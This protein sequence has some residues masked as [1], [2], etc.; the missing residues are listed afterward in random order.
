[1]KI[2]IIGAGYVG[3]VSA[4][5]FAEI[6]HEVITVDNNSA[7]VERLKAGEVPIHEE[8]L[9]E[10]L[11][12][13]GNKSLRYSDNVAEA[14]KFCDVAF[15]CVGT[16]PSENG[17]A[18][19]SYVEGVARE[20]AVSLDR[21]KVIVEK[22]TVPVGTCDAIKRTLL[23][24][25]A[26]QG[27]FS[28]ASNPEFLREGTAVRDFLYPDRILLG[29]HD[30][31]TASMLKAVYAPL[32][33]GSYYERPD[34][35]AP[36]I[37]VTPNHSARLIVTSVKSAELIKHASNAF[38]ALKISFINAVSNVCERVGA[39]VRE[40]ATGMGADSRIGP[41]F[42]QPGIGYGGSCFPKDVL[43]FRS[44]ARTVGY[45]F[46]LLTAVMEVNE[47]Q[48]ARFVAK[49]REA[50]WTLR[51]KR[52]AVL[53]LAFKGGT[54]D[55]RDS[56]AIE[57]VQLLHAGG[58][59]IIVFDPVAMANA[60]AVLGSGTVQYASDAYTACSGADAVLILTEWPE[61]KTLD[62][63]RI[64]GLLNLPLL[65]D[66]KNLL[67]PSA[68][69]AAGLTYYGV[70]TAPLHGVIPN[71]AMVPMPA[72]LLSESEPLQAA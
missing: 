70:G 28:I 14:F 19:L 9:P 17:D 44:V 4:A 42:L 3:L 39:D 43:A 38:L 35:I 30:E 55:V 37:G 29:V 65:L 69:S 11:R 20:L 45:N 46:D 15:I 52:L 25:G 21:H 13:H 22:S 7:R 32:L 61:F 72:V 10:L 16:P 67:D 57:I 18:D 51:G 62:L 2:A 53:G 36:P 5:C 26:Q 31:A 8:L 24:N 68:V 48:K 1:M 58:A 33:N 71:S 27:E 40:V 12:K 6:G 63:K 59:E 23:L 49:V 64:R 56:P 50:L 54:D 41:R 34:C 47:D 66:G 60:Q